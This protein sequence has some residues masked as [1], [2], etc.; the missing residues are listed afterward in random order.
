[1]I[2]LWFGI[3]LIINGEYV[4]HDILF[5]RKIC[6]NVWNLP[7]KIIHFNDIILIE[8]ILSFGTK[9]LMISCPKRL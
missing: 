9:K 1:M 5:W 2:G 6:S 8:W 7:C 4:N 3:F